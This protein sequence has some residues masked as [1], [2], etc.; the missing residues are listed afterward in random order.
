VVVA[1][2]WGK[3]TS[4][5]MTRVGINLSQTL[6]IAKIIVSKVVTVYILGN[7]LLVLD[8]HLS[9]LC[10]NCFKYPK[11]KNSSNFKKLL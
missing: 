4:E 10:L 11:L 8:I 6:S 2:K 5:L 3:N 1:D 9:I 7:N